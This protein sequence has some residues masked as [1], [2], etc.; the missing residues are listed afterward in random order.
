MTKN[1]NNLKYNIKYH[2]VWRTKYSLRFLTDPIR[3]RLVQI[4][5]DECFDKGFIHL[6]GSISRAYVRMSIASPPKYA[7]SQIAKIIK[8]VSS[9]YLQIEFPELKTLGLG[10]SIWEKGFYPTTFGE[11]C[12]EDIKHFIE[13]GERL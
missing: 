7:P 8:G 2:L 13:T 11:V 4:I 1:N 3:D 10:D 9:R 12:E 6:G 5:K